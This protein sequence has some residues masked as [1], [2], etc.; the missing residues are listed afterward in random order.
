M[1]TDILRIIPQD[2]E[3]VVDRDRLKVAVAKLQSLVPDAA[4][5]S[6][7]VSD[8]IEFLFQGAG[9]ESITCPLCSSSIDPS[10]WSDQMDVCHHSGFL[11][12]EVPT[13]CCGRTQDLNELQYDWPSG[14]AR[15]YL[16][17]R[18]PG[19]SNDLGPQDI[20][21]LQEILGCKLKQAWARY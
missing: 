14:F 7:E 5:V 3:L 6:Y 13:P 20:E 21:R 12:R 8:E 11:K 4:E 9:F 17:A 18:G 10:W 15:C 2:P 1:S 19:R 16:Q